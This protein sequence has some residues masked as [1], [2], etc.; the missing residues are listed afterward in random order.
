MLINEMKIW[1]KMRFKWKL[2]NITHTFFPK[3]EYILRTAPGTRSSRIRVKSSAKL[4][5]DLLHGNNFRAWQLVEPCLVYVDAMK[6][7]PVAFI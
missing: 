7:L 2:Y 6:N 4:S 3:I 5:N 1:L